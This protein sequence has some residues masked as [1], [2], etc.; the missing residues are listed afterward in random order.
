MTVK[1]RIRGWLREPL[2]HFLLAG[3]VIFLLFAWRGY[4]VD[5]A[6]RSITLDEAQVGRLAKNFE[7]T[8]QRAPTGDE[9]DGLIREYI[10][11]E[12]YYRE[13]LRLGLDSDDPVI[14]RRLRTKMEFLAR[15]KVE[16]VEPD[17]G[18]LQKILD[19]NPEKYAAD[20]TYSF[21]QVF[22][23]AFDPDIAG[24]K[25]EA[26]LEKLKAG[27]DW[28]NL[29]DPLSIPASLEQTARS[30][31]AGQFGDQFADEL[32]KLS[33]APKNKW[34]GPIGSGFGIHLIRIRAAGSVTKPKLSDVRQQVENDWRAATME[35]R[36]EQAYQTLL[37]G[38]EIKIAK[39]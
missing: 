1:D 3:L 30:E 10:K 20:A 25:A 11:E 36:E 27:A 39:P 6:S 37:D 2:I 32:A 38:Y 14:R 13:A 29:S 34:M 33:G 21:D 26:V 28:Q 22:L 8:F 16:S 9:L 5:P 7:Q 31:I 23:N 18:T 19:K 15:A 4:D 35:K 24:A 12:I 17:D